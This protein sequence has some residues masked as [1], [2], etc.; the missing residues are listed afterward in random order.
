MSAELDVA[1]A[2][3][4][5]YVALLEGKAH[6][7]FTLGRDHV[8]VF[9]GKVR[10]YE[11]RNGWDWKGTFALL[12]S[13]GKLDAV[14]V[15]WC[16]ACGIDIVDPDRIPLA[17]L[18]RLPCI[19]PQAVERLSEPHLHEQLVDVLAIE[20]NEAREGPALLR[21]QHRS[22]LLVCERLRDLNLIQSRLSED[23]FHALTG[24]E[25]SSPDSQSKT[26]HFRVLQHLKQVGIG[27]ENDFDVVAW[28]AGPG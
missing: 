9:D 13:V 16:F 21:R 5:G 8:F 28:M 27:L 2:D 11:R 20:A 6:N 1:L 17:I 7:D 25:L 4:I 10:D 18:A 23:L 15:H 12:A 22:K 19:F 24:T 14:T 3:G 26:L